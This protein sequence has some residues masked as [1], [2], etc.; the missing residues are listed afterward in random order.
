MVGIYDVR[1]D[2]GHAQSHA[3]AH[4][5]A[6]LLATDGKSQVYIV[7]PRVEV[8]T[9]TV[10]ESGRVDCATRCAGGGLSGRVC[11]NFCYAK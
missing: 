5:H 6:L 10:G 2:G 11:G 4:T 8:E 9:G 3:L 1:I 7:W